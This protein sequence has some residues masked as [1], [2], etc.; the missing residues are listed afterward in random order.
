MALVENLPM[1]PPHELGVDVNRIYLSLNEQG[2]QQFAHLASQHHFSEYNRSKFGPHG[3]PRYVPLSVHVPGQYRELQLQQKRQCS[4][5]QSWWFHAADSTATTTMSLGPSGSSNLDLV[6]E[7]SAAM[8]E[9]VVAADPPSYSIKTSLSHPINVSSI[10]PPET[11]SLISSQILLNS[12]SSRGPLF[13]LVSPSFSLDRLV[14]WPQTVYPSQPNHDRSSLPV[15]Q[16][17]TRSILSEALHAAIN[18]GISPPT[19][20]RPL[21][22]VHSNTS[23]VSLSL[24]IT[25]PPSPILTPRDSDPDLTSDISQKV[26]VYTEMK[27]QESTSDPAAPF[28]LGNLLMSSCPG[29]K[30]RLQG[31]VKGRSAVCRDLASDLR[32]MKDL[33]VACIVCCLD[34][35]ELEFLGAPWPQYEATTKALGLSTLRLRT[36]EGLA[37]SLSPQSLDAE[38]GILI[39]KYTLQGLNVLVH[40]RG[41][42]GRAGVVA[43]CWMI[44]LGLCGW[45]AQETP[46]TTSTWPFSSSQDV[47]PNSDSSTGPARQDTL[48]LIERVIHVV[49]RRRSVKAIETYEQVRFL[50]EFVEYLR[51]GPSTEPPTSV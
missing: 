5:G 25:A 29:K 24:S 14:L 37:P 48:Q 40:C 4:E 8:N 26:P 49:R 2:A 20:D 51:A 34:D 47:T 31:P 15:P 21:G 27:A 22:S 50:V 42:V 19:E 44:K 6:K 18:S 39:E 9:P 45:F 35:N 30:V 10:I 11:L 43:C 41:G 3:S 16:L 38:L 33:G 7:L 13:E 1:V 17:R 12:D 23:A 32:R 28:L 46:S 36:P